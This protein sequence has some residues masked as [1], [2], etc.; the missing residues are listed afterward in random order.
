[1]VMKEAQEMQR[2]LCM[3]YI[4]IALWRKCKGL[5]ARYVGVWVV[6]MWIKSIRASGIERSKG[7][8]H[9]WQV[10]PKSILFSIVYYVQTSTCFCCSW[11]DP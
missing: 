5:M 6:S 8:M 1:M 3:S 9:Q 2:R 4:L 11:K 7:V 10:R